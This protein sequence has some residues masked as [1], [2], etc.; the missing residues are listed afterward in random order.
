MRRK[1]ILGFLVGFAALV[2]AMGLLLAACQ[3]P[4]GSSPGADAAG[5]IPDG[6]GRLSVSLALSGSPAARAARSSAART[7]FPQNLVVSSYT[8]QFQA[9]SGGAPHAP[10]TVSGGPVGADPAA[11]ASADLVAG[12]YAVTVEG[13][14]D[15][16]V[17]AVG[18]KS[19][20]IQNGLTTSASITMGP[21][22]NVGNGTLTFSQYIPAGAADSTLYITPLAGDTPVSGGVIAL[23]PGIENKVSLPLMSGYYK[24]RLTMTLGSSLAGF[25]N[26]FIH[27]YYGFES[28]LPPVPI[29]PQPVPQRVSDFD[30][31]PYF[32]APAT[33]GTPGLSFEAAQ[34]DGVIQW[35]A[36]GAGYSGTSFEPGT[37]YTAAVTL[38]A[39]T[40][41][42]FEGVSANVFAHGGGN[43]VTNPAGNGITLTVTVVFP[44]TAA[45]GGLSIDIGFN[46][47]AIEVSG[48]NGEN[49][50]YKT[51]TPS[52]LTLSA[53]GY[54]NVAWY[55]DT[56]FTALAGNPVTLSAAAYAL[57]G[58][59]VTFNGYKDGVPF[60][61]RV[62]FAVEEGEAEA[63]D[64]PLPLPSV[65]RAE[66]YYAYLTAKG[67]SRGSAADP[68]VLPMAMDL[69]NGTDTFLNL[70]SLI[71]EKGKYVSVDLAQCYN[72]PGTEFAPDPET[73][74]TGKG[75]VVSLVLPDEAESIAGGWFD[76]PA[77]K[78]FGALKSVRGNNIKTIGERAFGDNFLDLRSLTTVDFP[79]ATAIGALAFH[80]CAALTTVNLPAAVSIGDGAFSGCYALTTVNFPAVVSIGSNA[81][82]LCKALTTVNFPE[83]TSIGV[84]AFQNCTALTTVSLRAAVSVGELAFQ[85]CTALTTVSLPAAVSIGDQAFRQCTALTT[86]SLPKVTSIGE[87]AFYKTGTTALTIT[88]PQA[89][90]TVVE[91]RL[92][93]SVTYSKTVTIKTP[94]G[95]TGY[96]DGWVKRSRT[97]FG[98]DAAIDLI[99]EDL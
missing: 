70:L 60:S 41:Y 36:G 20:T 4:Q 26:E 94:A 81:F 9:L 32:T 1:P 61:Q 38:Y 52:T 15:G 6:S 82:S 45:A 22:P 86:V 84:Y 96:D 55:V 63:G 64:F 91:R 49:I 25:N 37:V 51:G 57:G 73:I 30:L 87:L 27:I 85:N 71:G 56:D 28:P 11:F 8:L 16:T 88:L 65:E 23:T 80:C 83:A 18:T 44:P 3:F 46:H 31:T 76:F 72:M 89:A 98:D 10:V 33:W 34:Y 35:Q 12:T 66:A 99:F 42:T 17:I 48:S 95:R 53:G 40:G 78:G 5:A 29:G 54:D 75:L 47:E 7:A 39:E 62:A 93:A 13:S 21:K 68:I 19:V 97:S 77:F 58:H 69:G 79:K 90:P 50:I 43:S 14:R 67:D 2:A 74:G 59:N 92:Y 24:A